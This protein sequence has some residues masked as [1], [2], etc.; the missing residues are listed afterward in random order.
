[1]GKING[2]N[3]FNDV[4]LLDRVYT[5][6]QQIGLQCFISLILQKYTQVHI[7]VVGTYRKTS[8]NECSRIDSRPIVYFWHLL[9]DFLADHKIDLVVFRCVERH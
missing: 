6:S 1:M 5:P 2:F 9:E 3:F 8:V 4:V 7:A